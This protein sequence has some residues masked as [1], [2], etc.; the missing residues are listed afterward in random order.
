MMQEAIRTEPSGFSSAW[1]DAGS[2]SVRVFDS[3]AEL[4]RSA[5]NELCASSDAPVFM[6][7][8]FAAAV[9]AALK[10]TCR[11]WFV[12]VYDELLRPAACAGLTAMTVDF[13][14]FGDR[15]V[16]WI[17]KYAPF[18]RRF[19]NMRMLF[20]SLP[21]SPGDRSLV[22]APTADSHKV[23]ALLDREMLRL[24][25]ETRADAVIFKELAPT[26]LD[27]TKPLLE[28]G[29][30]RVEIPPMH[31]L[32]PAFGKTFAEYCA[33]L[34]TRYRQQVNKSVRKLKGS[35]IVSK[36]LTDPQDIL[37]HYTRETHAMYEEM[38][39]KSDLRIEVLPYEY[40]CELVRRMD[41]RMELISFIQDERMVAFGW[42]CY[43]KMTYH[44]MYAGVDYRLN[45]DFD[46]YFN[47]MYAGFDR[48]LRMGVSRIHVGQT[49][50]VFKAR[51]GCSHEQR[52]VY[53]KG[54][55]I[56]MSRLFRF[57]S[58][59]LVIKK[60]SNPPADIFKRPG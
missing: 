50:T 29:Y 8:R 20:C 57:G 54:V 10:P 35:D 37:R 41:G 42:C 32:D 49:A 23:L 13:T 36:I 30:Q 52:F 16:T 7:L 55:G 11:F 47:L 31:L 59:L 9:E 27:A 46:L 34:R 45:K 1:P 14:D 18:L 19:R 43:D 26:D 17:V 12:I 5:W 28:L 22:I 40:F 33:A 2:Y 15:R 24:A 38:T 4:E 56:F 25:A 51:M 6:D 21:G 3:V 53:T 44:M 60:P 48:A 39:R 58:S